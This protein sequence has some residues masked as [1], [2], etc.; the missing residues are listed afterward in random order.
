[1]EKMLISSINEG[2]ITIGQATTTTGHIELLIVRPQPE[3]L[4]I[5]TLIRIGLIT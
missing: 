2:S 1:M 3:A 5:G 4:I